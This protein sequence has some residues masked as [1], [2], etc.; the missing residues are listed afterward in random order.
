MLDSSRQNASQRKQPTQQLLTMP[1][2]TTKEA[3]RMA[4]INRIQQGV[5][6]MQMQTQPS[7]DQVKS[8]SP[9]MAE[10]MNIPGMSPH[11]VL[12]TNGDNAPTPDRCVVPRTGCG[13]L[14]DHEKFSQEHNGEVSK[15]PLRERYDNYGNRWLEGGFEYPPYEGR[16]VGDTTSDDISVGG[17]EA[18]AKMGPTFQANGD[19]KPILTVDGEQTGAGYTRSGADSG[20]RD[21]S[22]HTGSHSDKCPATGLLNFKHP[23]SNSAGKTNSTPGS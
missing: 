3:V 2:Q 16:E 10:I 20:V 23:Q 17:N 5:G 1:P 18:E 14:Y 4:A 15:N 12:Y 13:Q 21:Q 19:E 9:N 8:G 22:G 6:A 11:E 7:P